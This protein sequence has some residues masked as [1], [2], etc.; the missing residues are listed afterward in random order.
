MLLPSK[1]L[2]RFAGCLAE[3]LVAVG[4]G[5]GEPEAAGTE[6]VKPETDVAKVVDPEATETEDLTTPS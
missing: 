1:K 4:A 5:V 2:S 3:K 6:A